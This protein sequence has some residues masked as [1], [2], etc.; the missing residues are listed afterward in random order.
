MDGPT[1]QYDFLSDWCHVSIAERAVWTGKFSV[2][3]PVIS[4]SVVQ[5]CVDFLVFGLPGST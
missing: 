3:R 5:L 1:A 4:R 2:Y